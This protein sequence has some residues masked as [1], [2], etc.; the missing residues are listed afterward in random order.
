V[1]IYENRQ[2]ERDYI[3]MDVRFYTHSSAYFYE[4]YSIEVIVRN[5]LFTPEAPSRSG[6]IGGKFHN[7]LIR[8]SSHRGVLY[9]QAINA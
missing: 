9:G 4:Q 5:N 3:S 2:K 8:G 1:G 7:F 6:G